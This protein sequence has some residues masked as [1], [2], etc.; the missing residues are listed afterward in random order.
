MRNL[1]CKRIFIKNIYTH[2]IY[3][4]IPKCSTRILWVHF[5]YNAGWISW[6]L[7]S[8]FWVQPLGLEPRAWA[9]KSI[10]LC[11]CHTADLVSHQGTQILCQQPC[12][13]MRVISK[14]VV[15]MFP[16]FLSLSAIAGNVGVCVKWGPWSWGTASG[17]P[18]EM[19]DYLVPHQYSH[20]NAW[21]QIIIEFSVH[22]N[23][24][25]TEGHI[26]SSQS[27]SLCEVS[28]TQL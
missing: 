26:R 14:P 20:L 11:Q 25:V 19:A 6:G 4:Y 23:N 24:D 3:S 2:N 9:S 22:Y 15:Q 18:Y 28:L 13:A 16:C 1:Q 12:L 27:S 5:W 8:F 10:A 17:Y 7:C 21:H